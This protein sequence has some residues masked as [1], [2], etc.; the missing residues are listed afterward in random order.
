MIDPLPVALSSR[1]F[2]EEKE[3]EE[4]ML[5][6]RPIR[7]EFGILIV[8]NLL[9]QTRYKDTSHKHD[10]RDRN[11]YCQPITKIY[12]ATSSQCQRS[13]LIRIT[14]SVAHVIVLITI[15]IGSKK[16]LVLGVMSFVI[17]QVVSF[18]LAY[19]Y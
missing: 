13:D 9:Y 18:Y 3:E 2:R 14:R 17:I 19:T 10:F 15:W 1:G 4:L 16:V 6:T 8:G 5:N 11:M 12:L 7:W